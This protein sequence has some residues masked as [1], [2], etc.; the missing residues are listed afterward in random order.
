MTGS[1]QQVH[2]AGHSDGEEHILDAILNPRF[3]DEWNPKQSI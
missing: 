3:R 1:Q 2:S